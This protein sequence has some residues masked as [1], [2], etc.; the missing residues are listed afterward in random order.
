MYEIINNSK[1]S[2]IVDAKEVVKGGIKG[3]R[4]GEKILTVSPAIVEVSDKLGKSLATYQGIQVVRQT[5]DKK[6]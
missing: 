3:H 4:D 5:K 6:G 2:F 1:R